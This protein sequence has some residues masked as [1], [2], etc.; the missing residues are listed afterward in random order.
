MGGWKSRS[1]KGNHFFLSPD[2]RQVAGHKAMLDILLKTPFNTEEKERVRTSI[3][4][5][6][7][8]KLETLRQQKSRNHTWEE[9]TSLPE[10]WKSRTSNERHFFLSPENRQVVG[11]KELLKILLK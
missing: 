4:Q 7:D 8:K 10:G 9:D 5:V 1:S 3:A 2:N 6:K 11:H